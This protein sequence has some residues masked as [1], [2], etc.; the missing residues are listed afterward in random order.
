MAEYK[1][2]IVCDVSKYFDSL[3]LEESC[4]KYFSFICP[5]SQQIYSFTTVVQGP[6]NASFHSQKVLRN[7]VLSGIDG[8]VSFIDDIIIFGN[9]FREIFDIFR[10]VLQRFKEYNLHLQPQKLNMVEE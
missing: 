7:E 10:M 1:F 8:C 5:V 4:Q 6:R 2:F 9:T 3:P